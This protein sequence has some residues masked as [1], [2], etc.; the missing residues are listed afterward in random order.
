MALVK[1]NRT[2]TKG[3]NGRVLIVGGSRSYTGAPMLSAQAALRSGADLA[4]VFVPPEVKRMVNDPQIIACTSWNPFRGYFSSSDVGNVL[5]LAKDVDCVLLGPGMTTKQGVHS[6]VNRFV[7]YADVP[8]VLDADALKTVD[9][10]CLKGKRCVLTPHAG[11]F[12][13]VFGERPSE[14]SI[15]INAHENRVILLKGPT[16]RISDG[17]TIHKN[18]TGNAGL[19]VGGTGDILAGMVASFI[20]QGNS[21][22]DAA[23]H[24]ALVLGEC[25]DRLYR[26]MGYNYTPSDIL[27]LLPTI[28]KKFNS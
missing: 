16:D 5:S 12:E 9:L 4:T 8:L 22:L 18:T 28:V 17:E 27:A 26:R 10:S 25:G 24:A 13:R 23:Y 7:L 3:K 11:E 20:A 21:L 15:K 1:R 19:T 14:K 6:F 2:S